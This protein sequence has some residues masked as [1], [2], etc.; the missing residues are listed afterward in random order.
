MDEY[1]AGGGGVL[2]EVAGISVVGFLGS[3]RILMLLSR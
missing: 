1:G 3:N 2:K